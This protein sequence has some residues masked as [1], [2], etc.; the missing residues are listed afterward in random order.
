MNFQELQDRTKFLLNFNDNQVGEDFTATRIKQA[1]NFAYKREVGRAQLEGGSRH[2][3][4][5][6]DKTWSSG[7]TTYTLPADLVRKQILRI[8]DAT[9]ST[10]GTPLLNT[11]FFKD[12]ST[13]QW[14]IA[15]P[16][17][18][19][20]V[21]FTIVADAEELV[22]DGD[23]PVLIPEPYQEIIIWAAAIFLRQAADEGTPQEWRLELSELRMDFIKW[24]SRGHPL[25]NEA[26]GTTVDDFG[27]VGAQATQDGSSI[28]G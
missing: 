21:R 26:P 13:L 16:G 23:I 11:V 19:R 27:I 25:D 22:A 8:Q 24:L 10:V 3:Q 1:I 7:E 17:S 2:F 4:Q 20:T 12:R 28:G 15:G 18:D 5:L 14:G 9:D 6:I